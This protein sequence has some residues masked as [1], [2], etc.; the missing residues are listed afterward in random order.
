V[1][2]RHLL[3]L[4]LAGGVLLTTGTAGATVAPPAPV[5]PAMVATARVVVQAADVAV[6]TSAVRA[7]GGTV[8]REVPLIGAV[9]A[10]VPA[11]GVARLRALRGVRAVTPD[12]Q[13]Q[14]LRYQESLGYDP[15]SNT[16]SLYAIA[17]MTGAHQAY[18]SGITGKGV[19]VA[20]IDTGVAPVAGLT[21]GNVV[22]G[23]DLSFDSQDPDLV[24]DDSFGHGT[25]MASIIAGR[26]VAELRGRDY[27]DRTRFVGMAPDA[28][29][30][31][32]KVAASDG[33]TDVSQVL[34]AINWVV[35][36]KDQDGMN[37]RVLNL[38]YGT[39]STQDYRVDPLAHAV[40]A[41]WRA[42]IVV[43]VAGGNDGSTVDRLGMPAQS[44]R[45]LA[46]GAQ[47]PM[48]TTSTSDDR[49]PSWASKGDTGRHNRHV[50][51]VAPGVSVLGLRSP[52]SHIDHENPGA[53]TGTRFLRGNGTSQA[54][55][56]TSGAA[57]LYLQAYP[58]ATPDQ[59]KRA[60]MQ[61]ATPLQVPMVYRGAGAL[62][63][64]AALDN[65]P[66]GPSHNPNQIPSAG[67]GSLELSRGSAH[68]VDED[69]DGVTRGLVGERDIFGK[70]FDASSWAAA[71]TRGGTWTGGSWNG[72]DWT[73][74][75]WG[76]SS[77]AGRTWTGRTWTGRT[78]TGRTWTGRTWTGDSWD[79]RTWTGG[80]W[81]GVA[82]Q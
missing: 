57:A 25:H 67:T 73:G 20:L 80:N 78:W 42:G 2:P 52:H 75:D 48:G 5:A 79:G 40:E 64:H 43:V 46:V 62:D 53:R 10:E 23:P 77:W 16:G 8:G 41:A 58:H 3:P 31:N 15:V 26:D 55:A 24:H 61:A 14:P 60:L 21:S 81:S 69:D 39:D 22:N 19:D 38:S 4:V 47:D 17:G 63:L 54:A 44:P 59:V 74:T 76:G 72:S 9:A 11:A 6:A 68:V 12:G 36:N 32:V 33:A 29:L 37:I 65:A 13:L 45:V 1:R 28:R 7:V 51:L 70:R 49:V 18:R 34:A 50:D 30:V 66:V 27:V 35:E 56:V 71:T 82:W